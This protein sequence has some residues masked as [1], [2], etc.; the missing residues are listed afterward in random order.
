MATFRNFDTEFPMEERKDSGPT[1]ELGGEHFT[2]VPVAPAGSVNDLVSGIQSDGGGNEIYSI[3]NL[4]SF[5]TQVLRER[6]WVSPSD[7]QYEGGAL[8]GEWVPRD[9][10]TRFRRLIYDK[11]RPIKVE[12]LGALVIWLAE[13]LTL[14]PTTPSGR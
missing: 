10:V 8:V 7:A 9:D 14:R 13:Q 4:V 6:E 11:D 3:P 2:C 1:F 12:V 5:M